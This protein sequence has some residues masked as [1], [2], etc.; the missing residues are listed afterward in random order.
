MY[1]NNVVTVASAGF[2]GSAMP[3]DIPLTKQHYETLASWRHALRRFLKFSQDAA[4]AAG[5]PPQQHQALLAIKG[6]PGREF[7]TIT[8]LA[9]RLH[10]KHH[11]AVG[12]VDRLAHREL[13]ERRSSATDRRRIEVRLTKRGEALIRKLSAAHLREIV[14]LRP[15]LERLLAVAKPGPPPGKSQGPS[16][17]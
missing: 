4:R 17:K 12:I 11:S 8:E 15:E 3:R 10:L 7:V 9:D 1:F 6:F 16:G 14:Q 2:F 5:L 13:V